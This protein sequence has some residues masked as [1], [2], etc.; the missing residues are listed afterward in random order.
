MDRLRRD[1][2][3]LLED[4]LVRIEEILI[5]TRITPTQYEKDIHREIKEAFQLQ[6]K[7]ELLVSSLLTL[8][9]TIVEIEAAK[10][11]YKVWAAAQYPSPVQIELDKTRRALDI[12]LSKIDE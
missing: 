6:T 2:I 1:G 3:A 9:T 5:L 10:H 4:I 8:Y 7:L 11:E 12:Y